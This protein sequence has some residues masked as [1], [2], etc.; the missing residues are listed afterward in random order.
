[1]TRWIKTSFRGV[2]YHEH[3]TRKHGVQHDKY[4]TIRYKVPGKDKAGKN[5]SIDKEEGLGWASDGWTAAKAYDRL[6]ELKE[7]RKIGHGPQTLAEKR[8]LLKKHKEAEKAALE[9]AEKENITFGHFWDDIYF[10]AYK[11]GRKEST[12]R[13]GQEHFKNWIA[14]VI[15]KMPLKDIKPFAIEKIKKNV[16]SAG[17]SPRTLQYI[18]ATLR[19]AW[20]T[21]R[22]N[23]LIVGD[24]PTKNI[25]PPKVDNKRVRFLSH[26]EAET[27]LNAL[28]EADT[29]MH[30]LAL[31]SLQAGL[32]F[33]EIAA[34]KWG[35]IDVDRGIMEIVDPKGGQGRIAFMTQKIKAMFK[36]RKRRKPDEY[37]FTKEN[38]EKLKDPPRIFHDVIAVL[39]LNNGVT[40]PRRKVVFHTCRHTFASWHVSAGTDIYAVKSLLGHS[41]ISMTERYSHL[42][43]ETLQNATRTLEKAINRA[44]HN[45][46][47]QG[48]VVNFKK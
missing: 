39:G 9:K 22:L 15:G 18:M 23:G 43:P 20:N 7:N 44:G 25:K 33:G 29:L 36:N 30:D 11:I 19:Q 5:K 8:E 34:L 37:I 40:D 4:F 6:R 32:R 10:P 35:H 46:K 3:E 48:Q 38:G 17:R 31:L 28:Q 14:P 42:A 1:M 47:D 27:L 24:S 12:T 26:D 21:A 13:K 2:R 16:L 41:N 45:K